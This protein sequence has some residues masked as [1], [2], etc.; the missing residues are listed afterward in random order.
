ME[1][2]GRYEEGTGIEEGVETVAG[3]KISKLT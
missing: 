3:C 2:E 1:I